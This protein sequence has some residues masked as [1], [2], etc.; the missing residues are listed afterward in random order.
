MAVAFVAS[1]KQNET[2]RKKILVSLT[3]GTMPWILRDPASRTLVWIVNDTI[4]DTWKTPEKLMAQSFA[5]FSCSCRSWISENGALLIQWM[6][7]WQ[8]LIWVDLSKICTSVADLKKKGH[9]IHITF[10]TWIFF[11]PCADTRNANKFIPRGCSRRIYSRR[12]SR[13][14]PRNHRPAKSE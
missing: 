5:S 10:I 14:R 12:S 6:M 2:H 8:L 7:Q 9:H 4:N 3:R 11:Q 1:P 13:I